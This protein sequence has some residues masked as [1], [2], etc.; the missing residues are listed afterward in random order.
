MT[1]QGVDLFRINLS[2]TKLEDLEDVVSKIQS[3]TH[4]P[5]CLDS[6]GAQ[7]RNQDMISER[8]H[9]KKGSEITLHHEHIIGDNENISFTPD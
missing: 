5:V 6:E 9:F 7:I 4:V 2:H 3:W 8:V 1:E